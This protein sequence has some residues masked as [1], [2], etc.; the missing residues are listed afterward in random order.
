[1]SDHI[2]ADNEGIALDKDPRDSEYISH[3]IMWVLYGV[4]LYS[5]QGISLQQLPQIHW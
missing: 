1:M 2:L 3:Q 5:R 4:I